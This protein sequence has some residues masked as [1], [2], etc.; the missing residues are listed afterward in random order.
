VLGLPHDAAACRL[1]ESI[2][3]MCNALGK[4]VVAE[5]VETEAQR[6]TLRRAG[7]TVIQG[8]LRGH[9]M[10]AAGIPGLIRQ[11]RAMPR[12]DFE[13]SGAAEPR[14]PLSA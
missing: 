13:E 9:P 4:N 7:C 5:G 11:L 6:Q 12:Q 8:Y 3:V 1:A 10:E 14:L 2:I